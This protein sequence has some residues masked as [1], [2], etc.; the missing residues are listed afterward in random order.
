MESKS[1][2]RTV[3]SPPFAWINNLMEREQ[4]FDQE[5]NLPTI[6]QNSAHDLLEWVVTVDQNTH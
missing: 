4:E 3:E 2:D 6:H 1:L 5:L